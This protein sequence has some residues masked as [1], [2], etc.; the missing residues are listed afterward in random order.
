MAS[1]GRGGA[2]KA[3]RQKRRAREAAVGGRPLRLLHHGCRHVLHS[4]ERSSA[5]ED[6]R[7]R[8]MVAT[9]RTRLPDRG[10][11]TVASLARTRISTPSQRA[12]WP[13]YE[14]WRI[15]VLAPDGGREP[16]R[17]PTCDARILTSS[18]NDRPMVRRSTVPPTLDAF[19]T[20]GAVFAY[21]IRSAIGSPPASTTRARRQSVEPFLR[22][23][24]SSRRRRCNR[25]S[26]ERSYGSRS[27]SD[28]PADT[29]HAM[30]SHRNFWHPSVG[31]SGGP[32]DLI[33][34]RFGGQSDYAAVAAKCIFNSNS[35]GLTQSRCEWS[36]STL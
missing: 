23:D 12:A 5:R 7:S 24:A 14:I 36:L 18:I 11:A 25:D 19:T 35:L 3:R 22:V 20:S 29:H 6:C 32:A 17:D 13:T 1:L 31:P 16:A 34:T 9:A 21:A 10:D 2:T 27:V 8:P 15:V 28:M 4:L 30:C 26:F 33:L